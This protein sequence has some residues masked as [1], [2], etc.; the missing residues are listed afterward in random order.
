M[1]RQV[2]KCLLCIALWSAAGCDREPAPK[3]MKATMSSA[4]EPF[5]ARVHV[6]DSKRYVVIEMPDQ[7]SYAVL[8]DATADAQMLPCHCDLKECKP[9]CGG[10]AS[11]GEVPTQGAGSGQPKQ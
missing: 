2:T 4:G 5:R 3:A 8:A 9:M 7:R 11:A 1:V 10:P 6:H